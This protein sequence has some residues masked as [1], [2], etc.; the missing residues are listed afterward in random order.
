[1]VLAA[2]YAYESQIPRVSAEKARALMQHYG[3]DEGTCGFFA[4]HTYTSALHAKAWRTEILRLV[5]RND[6]LAGPTLDAA[7]RAS[8]WLW[9]ALDGSHAYRLRESSLSA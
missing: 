8:E 4:V 7:G 9:R 1:V 5:T 6:Q 3:A 2:I